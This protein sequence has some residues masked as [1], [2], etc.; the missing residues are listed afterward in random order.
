LNRILG[1][2]RAKGAYLVAVTEN[3]RSPLAQ[4]SDLLLR[5]RVKREADPF[6]LLATASTLAAIAVFDAICVALMSRR[7]FTRGRFAVIHP[8]GAVGQRLRRRT[9]A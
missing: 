1:P 2:L 9:G 5:V 7:G 8:G 4:A 3:E 6:N